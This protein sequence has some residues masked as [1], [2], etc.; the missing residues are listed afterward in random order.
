MAKTCKTG[1]KRKPLCVL[2]TV[3]V[4]NIALFAYYDKFVFENVL[5]LD[6]WIRT[7]QSMKKMNNAESLFKLDRKIWRFADV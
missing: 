7:R 6:T 1:M 2:T 4:L 5:L 3:V